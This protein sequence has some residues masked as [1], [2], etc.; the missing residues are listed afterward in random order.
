M[1]CCFPVLVV[2]SPLYGIP[3]S[4][5]TIL[6][7]LPCTTTIL[8][9]VCGIAIPY[10]SLSRLSVDRISLSYSTFS[11]LRDIITATIHIFRSYPW[12][13]CCLVPVLSRFGCLYEL[14]GF[15]LSALRS[16][17]SDISGLTPIGQLPYLLCSLPGLFPPFDL[18]IGLFVLAN[19][20]FTRE[21]CLYLGRLYPA[22]PRASCFQVFVSFG[23]STIAL[24]FQGSR[25]D[26]LLTGVVCICLEHRA[27]MLPTVCCS[28]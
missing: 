2:D 14:R 7:T 11:A 25:I 6:T 15:H 16:C 19:S 26:G 8:F 27:F 22:S 21:A 20:S 9:A 28:W 3:L 23:L 4:L 5:C 10:S 1:K 12:S 18:H 17:N 13:G 24:F